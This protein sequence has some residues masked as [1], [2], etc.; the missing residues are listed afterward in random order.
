MVR[1][2]IETQVS[3]SNPKFAIVRPHVSIIDQNGGTVISMVS[4][5]QVLTREAG[6]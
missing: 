3:R 5:G 4:I 1:E 6:V 2:V